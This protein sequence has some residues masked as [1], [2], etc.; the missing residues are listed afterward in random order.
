MAAQ[1]KNRARQL[2]DD[3]TFA[4]N[5]LRAQTSLTEIEDYNLLLAGLKEF[6]EVLK[7]M[8]IVEGKGLRVVLSMHF[9]RL[10]NQELAESW[11]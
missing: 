8:K 7:A 10:W 2:G 3:K 1:F 6:E 9:G 4:R 11:T 5:A